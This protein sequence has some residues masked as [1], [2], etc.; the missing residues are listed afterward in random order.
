MW[1][2]VDEP[3]EDDLVDPGMVAVSW[4]G[5]GDESGSL[6]LSDDVLVDVR[7]PEEMA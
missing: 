4:R 6:S 2:V 5:D 1:V 7:H 3:P